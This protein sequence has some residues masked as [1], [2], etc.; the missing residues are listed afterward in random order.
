MGEPSGPPSCPGCGATVDSQYCPFCGSRTLS[1]TE[2]VPSGGFQLSAEEADAPTLPAIPV[3]RRMDG[4]AR[5]VPE[6]FPTEMV[7]TGPAAG[8]PQAWSQVGEPAPETAAPATGLFPGWTGMHPAVT[9][10]GTQ[11]ALPPRA[12]R[13]RKAIFAVLGIAA[14]TVVVLVAAL[15]LGP[16]LGGST[17]VA[18]KDGQPTAVSPAVTTATSPAPSRATTN[19]S[20]LLP[21]PVPVRTVTVTAK[22]TVTAQPTGKVSSTAK[23]PPTPTSKA[24]TAAAP[25]GV[26]QRDITCNAG[27]IVQLASEFDARAFTARV[28][29][30]KRAGQVPA[31]SLAADSTRSC[32]IFTSQTNTLVL[33][34]GPFA[35]KY[36]GCPARLA[37]PADA[38]IKGSNTGTAQDY[39]SCLCPASAAALPPISRIGQQGVWVGE[40]QRVLG[41][42]LNVAVTDLAGHWGVFTPGTKAAVQKFQQAAKLPANGAVDVRTWQSLQSAQC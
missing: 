4:P 13:R 8:I 27:Y 9:G 29:G 5:A 34:V 38:F 26:P 41:N 39:I 6:M 15:L 40:L 35:S 25:L 42:R 17:N 33:Y 16:R 32:Q 1:S 37:G 3:V 12:V 31:G 36:A 21:E 20:A 28:A 18:Q 24:T 30:L 14:A 10:D 19:G 23:K 2:Q 7:P 11:G 22:P